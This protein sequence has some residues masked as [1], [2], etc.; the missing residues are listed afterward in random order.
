MLQKPPHGQPCNNCGECCKAELCPLGQ[1]LF[2][3]VEGPCPALVD[4]KCGLVSHPMRFAPFRTVAHGAQR[5]SEAAAH[6]IGAGIGCDAQLEDEPYDQEFG[7][8][9]RRN[10][11]M[12]RTARALRLWVDA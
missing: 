2:R 10:A 12:P 4:N 11:D 6:C 9:I 7:A 3:Q 5:M 8:R 1:L